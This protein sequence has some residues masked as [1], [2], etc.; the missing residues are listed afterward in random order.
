MK[1]DVHEDGGA[2]TTVRSQAGQPFLHLLFE[3]GVGRGRELCAG[4]GLCG[5]CRI[6]FRSE[7]PHP[8]V[9][10]RTRLTLKQLEDGWRLGCKHEVTKSCAIEVPAVASTAWPAGTGK[11][12]AVDIG[13]TRIKW[14]LG[15]S[16]GRA[17]E[18]AMVNPQM[19]VGSEIMSRLRYALSSEF[20]RDHL[21][22]SVSSV[23]VD[24]MRQSKASSLAVC[25]NS[26]MIAILLDVSL[27]GLAHAPYSTPWKG[28][29]SVRLDPQLPLAYIPPLLGPFI[30]AD[31]SAGLAYIEAQQPEYPYLLADLGT[32]GEFVLA[33][34]QDRYYA[35]SVP[36]GPAIEG[37]GLCCGAMAGEFVLDR[38]SLGPA[39]LQWDKSPLAGISG[40]GYASVLALLRRLGLIDEDG[41]F[42]AASMPLAHKISQRIRDHRLG[43]IFE[44]EPGA[45]VAER[46]IEEFLK[47]K[48]GVNV[49]LRAL[50]QGAG[51]A[52]GEVARVY[53]AG[54]LGEHVDSKD[55]I[56][57]GF[58]PEIWREKIT[59]AGNTA[60]A[61][62]MLA[63]EQDDVRA[64]LD[65]LPGRMIVDSLAERTD[66]GPLFMRAMRFAWI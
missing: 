14:A 48:A 55:L 6:R 41:H 29:M 22:R 24:L 52:E 33:L 23:I 19:G 10:D 12:L 43:R 2:Q 44:L 42:Q 25:G 65:L 9:E 40:T 8:C 45:F 38:V 17:R 35:C 7:A 56:T 3:A 54:A 4:V 28:G 15:P 11:V 60:L 64:W 53:L 21:R 18:M 1:I 61:G 36:M 49:A 63:L 47:A 27:K 58:F 57:L 34:D 5:K 20:A 66:F 32:N 37:V 30:G 51:L 59:V 16:Q 26:A 31:I 46:D 50:I 62:T 39:G 13:T